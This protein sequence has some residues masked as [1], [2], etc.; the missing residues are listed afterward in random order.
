MLLQEEPLVDK[1]TGKELTSALWDDFD[2]TESEEA[3]NALALEYIDIVKYN[4]ECLAAKLPD[5]FDVE[6][7]KSAGFFGLMDAID[8]FDRTRGVKFETYCVPRIRG[9]MLDELRKMDW[10]PRLVRSHVSQLNTATKTLENSLGRSPTVM[11]LA[12]HLDVSINDIEKLQQ[13][14]NVTNL[15]SLNKKW[16][17]TDSQ[18]DVEE[19]HLL[20]DA[21]A[22][23][24]HEREDKRAFISQLLRGCSREER[25]MMIL[26]YYEDNT[27]KEIAETFEVSESR[28]S[29]ILTNLVARLEIKYIWEDGMLVPG[30]E[31][32]NREKQ[33]VSR[34]VDRWRSETRMALVN[35]IE[36]LGNPE[37]NDH[38]DALHGNGRQLNGTQIPERAI[39]SSGGNDKKPSNRNRAQATNKRGREHDRQKEAMQTSKQLEATVSHSAPSWAEI[40]NM[41]R[42]QVHRDSIAQ[43]LRDSIKILGERGHRKITKSMLLSILPETLD[44]GIKVQGNMIQLSV[45]E[46]SP[47]GS[48]SFII[49]TSRSVFSNAL[50]SQ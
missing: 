17:E 36:K 30:V 10:V 47:L 50:V 18:K 41:T 34:I 13:E 12:E 38:D 42:V 28:V 23:S 39:V 33:F 19:I 44:A 40:G 37:M 15:I 9:A 35:H 11:E 14:A 5:T 25:L 26:Y 48:L 49:R 8:A 16:Y 32:K 22:A 46:D 2:A 6:D 29:Q 20:A 4:A 24:P 21:K 43:S 27:M 7:L 3:R 45:A 31:T 1:G